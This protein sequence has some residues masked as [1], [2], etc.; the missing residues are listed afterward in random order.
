MSK[1]FFIIALAVLVLGGL[2]VSGIYTAS[3]ETTDSSTA[4]TAPNGSEISQDEISKLSEKAFDIVDSILAPKAAENASGFNSI[5]QDMYNRAMITIDSK[6][7]VGDTNPAFRQ[8]AEEGAA[9]K[10]RR[11]EALKASYER[12]QAKEAEKAAWRKENGLD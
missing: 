10:E 9:Q 5:K 8:F 3:N 7:D 4:I 2:V 6:Q 12:Y 11:E 1:R